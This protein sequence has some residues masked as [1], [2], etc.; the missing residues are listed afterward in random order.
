MTAG[1][2]NTLLHGQSLWLTPLFLIFLVGNIAVAGMAVWALVYLALNLPAVHLTPGALINYGVVWHV[3]LPWEEIE[4]FTYFVSTGNSK[5]VD[6]IIVFVKDKRR[7][8]EQHWPL[9]RVLCRLFEYMRPLTIN[10][11]MTP[12]SPEALAAQIEWY[13]RGVVGN[14][15]IK[16]TAIGHRGSDSPPK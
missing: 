3:V 11:E 14:T 7:I 6:S 13:V 9:T 5:K 4:E 12:E 1:I 2:L 16:F 15:H 10:T 8:Y